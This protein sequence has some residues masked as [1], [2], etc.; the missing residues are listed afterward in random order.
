[1][2]L[3]GDVSHFP[4]PQHQLWYSFG[5]LVGQGFTQVKAYITDEGFNLVEVPALIMVLETAL[6]DPDHMATVE[7]KMEVLK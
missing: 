3:A 1:M 7:R 2:K 5:L 4:N 6:K